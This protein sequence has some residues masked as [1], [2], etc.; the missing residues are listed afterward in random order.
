[1][2]EIGKNDTT[3]MSCI[4]FGFSD[5]GLDVLPQGFSFCQSCKNTLVCNQRNTQV[6]QQCSAMACLT[7]EMIKS[8]TVSHDL[9]FFWLTNTLTPQ[10]RHYG[11]SVTAFF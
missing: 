6:H 3:A 8:F 10:H 11:F 2:I 1:M 4:R 7:P 5:Q 9:L